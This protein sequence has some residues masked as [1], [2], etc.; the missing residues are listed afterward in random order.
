MGCDVLII[1]N[2]DSF[3]HNLYQRLGELGVVQADLEPLAQQAFSDHCSAT[4]PRS[5][6][7]E[8]CARLYAQAL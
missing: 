2:Y 1:D 6:S 5:V 7:V 4:N 8:D 3:T